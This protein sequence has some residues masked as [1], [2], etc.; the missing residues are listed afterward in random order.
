MNKARVS[1]DDRE[2]SS[3]LPS[4]PANTEA[5]WRN[6]EPGSSALISETSC[7]PGFGQAFAEARSTH[8]AEE[9]ARERDQ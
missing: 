8:Q 3:P 6:I 2:V 5:A 1:A 9:R 7:A 4:Y